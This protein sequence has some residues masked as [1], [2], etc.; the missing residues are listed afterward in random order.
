MKFR[1]RFLNIACLGLATMCRYRGLIITMPKN[2][3]NIML[4]KKKKKTRQRFKMI[5]LKFL[6]LLVLFFTQKFL[7]NTFSKSLHPSIICNQK[8]LLQTLKYISMHLT[9]ILM[10]STILRDH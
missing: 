7:P 1:I 4:I 8:S 9:K 2:W 5:L 6:I 3:Q 10:D